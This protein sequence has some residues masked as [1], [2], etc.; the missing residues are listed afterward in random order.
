MT[1]KYEFK[2]IAEESQGHKKSRMRKKRRGD[3]RIDGGQKETEGNHEIYSNYASQ[4]LMIKAHK[5]TTLTH[6]YITTCLTQIPKYYALVPMNLELLHAP[7]PPTLT[8]NL[9]TTNGD[10]SVGDDDGG[11]DGDSI[12]M[13]SEPFHLEGSFAVNLNITLL[14]LNWFPLHQ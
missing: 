6:S 10:D 2:T 9:P 13:H 3:T 5:V 7:S 4:P 14:S 8:T 12:Q 11:F 1:S